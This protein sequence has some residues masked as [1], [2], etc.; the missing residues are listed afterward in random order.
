MQE[1]CFPDSGPF[2]EV[3][4]EAAGKGKMLKA[5]K[6]LR[7]EQQFAQELHKHV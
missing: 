7:G 5:G 3:G 6:M 1:S 2:A 4:E